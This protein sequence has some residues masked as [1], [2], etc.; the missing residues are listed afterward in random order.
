[1]NVARFYEGR[2]LRWGFI[3][4]AQLTVPASFFW[5]YGWTIPSSFLLCA[6]FLLIRDTIGDG[7]EN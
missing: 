3:L 7:N 1:M 2:A 4:G 6:I 5:R